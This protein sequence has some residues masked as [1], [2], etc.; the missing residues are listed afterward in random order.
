MLRTFNCGVGGVLIVPKDSQ[1]EILK[2]LSAE[3]ATVIGEIV[4][5]K[6]CMYI[7]CLISQTLY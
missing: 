1:V 2:S 5:L 7:T 4:E 3:R 6:K